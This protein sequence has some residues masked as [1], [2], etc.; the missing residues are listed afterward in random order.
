LAEHRRRL[1]LTQE[2]IAEQVGITVEMVRRHEHGISMP[3]RPSRARYCELFGATEDELGLRPNVPALRS[4]PG[5][6]KTERWQ[7]K[8][9]A[10]QNPGLVPNAGGADVDDHPVSDGEPWGLRL[11]RW[12]D[13]TQRWSQQDL[14]DHI[15]R[16]AF[17]TKEDRGTRIDT[18]LVGRWESG[19]V[20]R[21]QA[22]YR[23]LLAQLGA[24]LPETP[25]TASGEGIPG[26][27]PAGASPAPLAS[28]DGDDNWPEGGEEA[29]Q[30]RDFL[31]T[32]S[33]VAIA[34]VLA[35]V[36]GAPTTGSTSRELVNDLR[37]R[38]ARLRKLDEHLGGGDTYHLYAEEAALTGQLLQQSTNREP[39]HNALLAL[40]SE[41]LQQAGWAAFDAGW[42]DLAK[43]HY[44]ESHAAAVE[45]GDA[46]L[47][48]NA[49]A[50]H[51]YQQIALGEPARSTSE[52]SVRA[53][54][55][56]DV[57]EGV[58]ALL[59]SRAAWTFALEG[60]AN[61]AATCLGQADD[62]LSRRSN[63]RTP[64][65][66]AW[67]DEN[68]LAI[69]T[70]RCWSELR[71]PL[72]AVPVLEKALNQ[73]S[74]V[75]ARDKA[76]Y[77]SWLANSYIDAGE[78]EQAAEVIRSSLAVMGDVASVRPR[79]RLAAVA[80]RLTPYRDLSPVADLLGSG[81]FDPLD[82]RR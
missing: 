55:R 67:I 57:D 44:R 52:R 53:A 15:V 79:Q 36:V 35:S 76:L 41:Q 22:V 48:G 11:R 46:G 14:V 82:I 71:R 75:H 78:I 28:V 20:S 68:E 7:D 32:G 80:G 56:D 24:P 2:Q 65:Y 59:F 45:A 73:Y 25:V 31:R 54:Q 49:L 39:T 37:R 6:R 42:H 74:D 18:R 3:V 33:A 69:M 34:G 5:N 17:Q 38:L 70:G 4:R 26:S 77:S 51:A 66:A 63:G 1:G 62:A 27:C 47:A 72:R 58:K 30:R 13:E 23:R 81:A 10:R 16:L 29:V 8:A 9:L 12:R 40:H 19:A 61:G 64:D 50:F 43:D 21:P 60:D